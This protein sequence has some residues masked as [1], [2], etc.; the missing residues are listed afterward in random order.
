MKRHP[1][2]LQCPACAK[3]LLN[4]GSKVQRIHPVAKFM[5]KY[6]GRIQ[7]VAIAL[8][9]LSIPL[10]AM[11]MP[12]AQL[13]WVLMIFIPLPALTMYFLLRCFSIHRVIDCP[14]CGYHQAV[15]LGRSISGCE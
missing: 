13:F 2:I 12:R 10:L 4:F 8:L 9:I 15:K 1:A 7:L 5:V 6:H 14:Y 3:Q 11:I